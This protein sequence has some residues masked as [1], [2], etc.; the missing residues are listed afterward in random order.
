MGQLLIV[1]GGRITA[2]KS[3]LSAIPVYGLSMIPLPKTIAQKL[4]SIQRN[5][6][7]G[8]KEGEKKVAWIKWDE[9]CRP[10]REGGLGY[11]DLIS[12]NHALLG[13]WVWRFLSGEESLWK[14]IIIS[15]HGLPSWAKSGGRERN[16]DGE[17]AVRGGGG[18]YSPLRKEKKVNGF[19]ISCI[20]GWGMAAIQI[21]GKENGWGGNR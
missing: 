17:V 8:S 14:K 9:L 18:K 15:W 7:W 11:K 21:F 20:E 4:T 5:F 2:L 12:L 13:K 3:V 19:G 10:K 6:L 1:N 16:L